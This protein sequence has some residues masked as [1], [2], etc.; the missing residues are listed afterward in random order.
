[1]SSL[2]LSVA[3]YCIAS[4]KYN[5]KYCSYIAK[6]TKGIACKRKEPTDSWWV[7]HCVPFPYSYSL[8]TSKNKTFSMDPKLFAKSLLGT[9]CNYTL[10]LD[11]RVSQSK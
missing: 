6:E 2:L 7:Q 4:F 10:D 9:D 8:C 11:L 5:Y 3:E 1:M